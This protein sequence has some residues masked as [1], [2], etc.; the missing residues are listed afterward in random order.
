MT[1]ITSTFSTFASNLCYV[2]GVNWA[3][4]HPSMPLIISG[5]DDRQIKLWRMNDNKVSFYSC[6]SGLL[7]DLICHLCLY[8]IMRLLGQNLTLSSLCQS[9]GL[10]A[11]HSALGKGDVSVA[12][13]HPNIEIRLNTGILGCQIFTEVVRKEH[14]SSRLTTYRLLASHLSLLFFNVWAF[15]LGREVLLG[16]HLIVYL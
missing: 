3:N 14:F 2:R 12:R 6:L 16:S 11:A 4:F 13:L 5:A 9:G 8:S 10:G 15:L 7:I 1:G